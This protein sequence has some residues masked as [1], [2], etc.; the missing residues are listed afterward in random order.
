MTAP[1]SSPVPSCT[2][3]TVLF[4]VT[5]TALPFAQGILSNELLCVYK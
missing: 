1:R 3:L 5:A 2:A 4:C